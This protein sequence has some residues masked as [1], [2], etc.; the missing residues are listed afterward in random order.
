[1]NID[2]K[3]F[4][5]ISTRIIKKQ[6]III[7]PLAWDEARKVVG[8]SVIDQKKGYVEISQ[9]NPK[10]VIDKLVAQYER[11]FGRLSHEICRESVQDITTDLPS[12]QIP[13]S[14]K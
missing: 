1:M 14:L 8:L 5:Q 11:L 9:D 12:D 7:G 4:N 2:I 6:A 3:I 10:E 13:S